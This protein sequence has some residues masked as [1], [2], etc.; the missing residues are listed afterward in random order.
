MLC[1]MI[2]TPD[3]A[4]FGSMADRGVE[5]VWN[6]A[7]YNTFRQELDWDEPPAICRSCAVCNGTF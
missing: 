5:P 6:S 7:A 1:C 4:N 3:R 2:A